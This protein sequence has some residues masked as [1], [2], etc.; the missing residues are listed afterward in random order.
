MIG[1]AIPGPPKRT[2]SHLGV[3]Q[4]G[5]EDL[6][7]GELLRRDALFIVIAKNGLDSLAI[8]VDAVRPPVLAEDPRVRGP[9]DG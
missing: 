5:R 1:V 4:F 9:S 6:L 2:P 3:Q 7:H 8:G